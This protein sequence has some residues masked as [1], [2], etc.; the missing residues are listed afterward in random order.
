MLNEDCVIWLHLLCVLQKLK[1]NLFQYLQ[2]STKSYKVWNYLHDIW[3]KNGKK[4]I[5]ANEYLCK[6]LTPLSLAHWHMG[7][8]GWT[9]SVKS[10]SF[11]NKFFWAAKNDVERLIAILNKKFELNCTLHSNNRIY[12]PVKSAVKFCQIV[13]P[14]M[15]PGMLYKVDKSITRPNLSSIVPSSS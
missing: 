7:D 8:G 13:T 9:P 1:E 10:Y 2:F 3:Y 6:L 14:H 11:R 4:V 12:I 5:P 15:E